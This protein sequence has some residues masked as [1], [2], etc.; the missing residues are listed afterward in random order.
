MNLYR[1]LCVPD[2]VPLMTGRMTSF[3]ISFAGSIC[4]N[5]DADRNYLFSGFKPECTVSCQSVF[6]IL[7]QNHAEGYNA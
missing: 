1:F 4:K 3:L 5:S 6:N 2:S 7:I